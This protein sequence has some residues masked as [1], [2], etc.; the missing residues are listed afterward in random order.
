M[1]KR[2]PEPIPIV[3]LRLSTGATVEVDFRWSPRRWTATLA[4]AVLQGRMGQ[5]GQENPQ[6]IEDA[7]AE[8]VRYLLATTPPPIKDILLAHLIAYAVERRLK[9]VRSSGG[10]PPAA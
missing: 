4:E 7:L 3:I 2:V 5:S 6:S 1:R 9:H 10:G 8:E